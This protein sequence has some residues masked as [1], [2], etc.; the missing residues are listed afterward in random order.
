MSKSI[1]YILLIALLMFSACK[2][3]RAPDGNVSKR[4]KID[5][6]SFGGYIRINAGEQNVEG[7]FIG[8]RNNTVVVITSS[9][10]VHEIPLGEVS[11]CTLIIHKVTP[12]M[13]TFG[14]IMG[15]ASTASNGYFLIFTAPTWLLGTSISAPTESKRNNV[16]KY[17]EESWEEIDKFARFPGGIPDAVNL[18]ELIFFPK[19]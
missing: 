8:T 4:T 15:I 10:E 5:K 13:I 3:A 16:V 6:T 19:K 11:S 7:E 9:S 2:V 14:G 18:N 17:P 1:S 12:E